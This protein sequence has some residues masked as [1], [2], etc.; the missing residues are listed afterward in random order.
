[1]SDFRPTPSDDFITMDEER[2]RHNVRNLKRIIRN[3][4]DRF[5]RS[6]LEVECCY[7]QREIDVRD[8]RRAAHAEWLSKKTQRKM[9]VR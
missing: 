9:E 4:R 3:S 8:R 1:M 2:L 5:K 7:V 6:Q